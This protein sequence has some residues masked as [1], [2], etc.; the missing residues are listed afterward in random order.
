MGLSNCFLLRFNQILFSD[1]RIVENTS[2]NLK[3]GQLSYFQICF[4]N[5][6]L[7]EDPEISYLLLTKV[8]SPLPASITGGVLV[9]SPLVCQ[10]IYW[11]REKSLTR[12]RQNYSCKSRSSTTILELDLYMYYV[13]TNSYTKFQVNILKDGCERQV[14]KTE[15]WRTDYIIPNTNYMMLVGTPLIRKH[16][17]SSLARSCSVVLLTFVRH[18][19]WHQCLR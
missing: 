3:P 16:Y 14:W 4:K 11:C 5:T 19:H 12:K 2:A 18:V 10:W 7:E 13:K 8:F 9:C 15:A 6:N 17:T 1:C